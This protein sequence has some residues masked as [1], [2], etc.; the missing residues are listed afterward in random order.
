MILSRGSVRNAPWP[1]FADA[2]ENGSFT[3]YQGASATDN[4]FL[5]NNQI[6]DMF[7]RIPDTVYTP[8]IAHTQRD[9][10]V[11]VHGHPLNGTKFFTWGQS[12]PGRFMQDF[13][14]GGGRR[15]GDYTELQIGPA[16][17]Q[18]QSFPLPKN[19]KLEWTEWFRGYQGD[20]LTLYDKDYQV[21]LDSIDSWMKEP[22]GMPK[23][24]TNDWD[25]FFQE[26]ASQPSSKI[27]VQGQPWGYLEQLLLKVESLA[28]G[29]TFTEPKKGTIAY[30]EA[31]PWIEL[32]KTGKFSDE[33]LNQLPLSYQ[34]TDN[35][36]TLLR[37]S[38]D[39]HG[40][41]WL[42]ALHIAIALT[43]RGD[44]EEPIQLFQKSY[45]MKPNPIAA[46]CLGIL[47]TS[48]DDAWSYFQQAWNIYLSDY[49]N[50]EDISS[51]LGL[52]LVTEMSFFLQQ[53]LWYDRMEAFIPT[54]PDEFKVSDAYITMTIKLNLYKQEY[55]Q[56]RETLASN[57][58]PT[59]A[60]ARSDLITFWNT[61]VEG[62]AQQNKLINDGG[63]IT[64]V[65]RHQA[66][67]SDPIPDNIGCVYA[68]EVRIIFMNL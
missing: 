67:M 66:R 50:D 42:H 36:L 9:G 68:S 46:R 56:A 4:S 52:N 15:Q 65:E 17:T 44:I 57:C 24:E 47:S 18:M 58:F 31:K 54:V 11:L 51:R 53:N 49:T 8:Y 21:A 1:Y 13:L 28:P 7:L 60:S 55:T 6:G 61:A 16:P 25:T 35:W 20:V 33:T 3:G 37:A 30:K 59:Y 2:Q 12:G 32:I 26:V 39:A 5:G 63:D 38:V 43:E 64:Y 29:L 40:L 23:S 34:T 45:D 19:S 22:E 27:L 41:T 10:Y 14:A 62:I 48:T